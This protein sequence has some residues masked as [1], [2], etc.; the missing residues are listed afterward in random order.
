M[1][2]PKHKFSQ[3]PDRWVPPYHFAL[4]YNGLGNTDETILCLNKALEQHDPKLAFLKVEQS[5]N[6]VRNDQRFQDVMKRAG[7]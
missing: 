3:E 2:E 6:N 1:A 5:W 4:I 7:F